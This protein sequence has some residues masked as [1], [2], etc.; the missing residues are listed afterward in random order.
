MQD[1]SLPHASLAPHPLLADICMHF[2][3]KEVPSCWYT[4]PASPLPMLIVVLNGAMEMEDGQT[5]SRFAIIGPNRHRSRGKAQPGSRFMSTTFRPGKL[6]N[7][8][9]YPVD[10]FSDAVINLA[11]V[12]PLSHYTEVNEKLDAANGTAAQL[13]VVQSMLLRLRLLEKPRIA[14]LVIPYHWINKPAQELADSL[15]LGTR[16]FERR[17][18]ASFGLSLRSY[19]QHLRYGTS[20]M[21][22]MLGRLPAKTWAECAM[23]FGYA[24]QAHMNH[25]FVRFTG[26]TPAQLMRGIAGQDPALW[27]FSFNEAELG[28]LFIP[29][30]EIDVVS[31][32]DRIIA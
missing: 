9:G 8:L 23:N 7:I 15:G 13:D 24:D 21:Q 25:D 19:K 3:V 6:S 5:L 27:A 22:V 1:P 16:Q 30:D 32:Q 18:L 29:S 20:L 28:E 12:L 14:P 10:E 26:H 31:V 11:D 17:F 4:V 2:L